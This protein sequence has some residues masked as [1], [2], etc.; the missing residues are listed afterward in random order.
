MRD[1]VSII[2]KRYSKTQSKL[3]KLLNKAVYSIT[4]ENLRNKIDGKLVSNE[5]NNLN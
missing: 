1:G 5:K 4:V 3:H 2:S